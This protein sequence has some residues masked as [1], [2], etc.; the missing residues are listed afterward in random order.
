M[1]LSVNSDAGSADSLITSAISNENGD[2]LIGWITGSSV[3]VQKLSKDGRKT[4]NAFAVNTFHGGAFY[5]PA[6][7]MNDNGWFVASWKNSVQD[8]NANDF[9]GI[10]AQVMTPGGVKAGPEFAI[11]SDKTQ[12]QDNTGITL[13]RRGRMRAVWTNCNGNFGSSS[14]IRTR[15]FTIDFPPVIPSGQAIPVAVGTAVGT[16][17]G[18]VKAYENNDGQPMTWALVDSPGFA[19]SQTGELSVTTTPT[20]AVSPTIAVKVRVTTNGKSTDQTVTISKALPVALKSTLLQP[21][22]VRQN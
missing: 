17:I 2:S 19:I 5:E 12:S 9:G 15:F 6:I 1:S 11:P 13:D 14:S 18:N 20:F 21:L 10:Y 16:V 22:D 4:G 7:A 3:M 8:G